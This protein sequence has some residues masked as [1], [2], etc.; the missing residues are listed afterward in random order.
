MKRLYYGWII[1]A[2]IL[3]VQTVSSGFGFYNMSVYMAELAA[4]MSRP[5][6]DLSFAVS[7]FFITGG[8]AGLF[9]AELIARYQIR[10]I[11]VAGSITCALAFWG[12]SY[13]REIWQVYSLFFLFGIGNTGVSLVI[14]TTLIT[15]WFPGPNR[16]IALSISST[17]L[18]LGGVT[19]TPLTAYLF[20]TVGVY[21]SFPLIG[22][23]FAVLII[24]IAIFLIRL[25]DEEISMASRGQMHDWGY[26]EA[27]RTRF[28]LLH[29]AGYA[30]CMAAQVGGIAHL[31]GRVDL[32]SDFETA[33]IAV[34]VLGLASIL[35]RFA[36]GVIATYVQIRTFTLVM[37]IVQAF[38]LVFIGLAA[39][40]WQ[41]IVA[42][43]VLGSSVGNLLMLQPL[44]LAD[45]FPGHV[46]PRVFAMASALSVF[47]V[48]AGP[49]LMGLVVDS[50]GYFESYG[51]A[52]FGCVFAWVILFASGHGPTK[53]L[54]SR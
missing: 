9:V 13:A 52:A 50:A 19:L 29:S 41:G 10:W 1:V 18:S 39:E 24:P 38:G 15:R 37:L 14:G 23:A 2:A 5:L 35:F 4:L 32:I 42:A 26:G 22:L 11:M 36:G 49:F 54:T 51:L 12:M 28:F 8:V 20:N 53:E 45:V 46:Y 43:F 31:Y 34:S 27:I 17:G 40:A 30:I 6:S 33:G 47:G 21:E 7:I 16:S 48:A 44:W 25:P 3:I